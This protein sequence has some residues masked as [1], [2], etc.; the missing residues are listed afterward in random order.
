MRHRSPMHSLNAIPEADAGP[1]SRE[2]IEHWAKLHAIRTAPGTAGTAAVLWALH[3]WPQSRLLAIG[4]P[5]AVDAIE[6]IGH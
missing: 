3:L 5:K 6:L 1:R 4:L 2:T